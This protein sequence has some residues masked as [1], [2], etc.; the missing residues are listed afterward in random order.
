MLML[1]DDADE[2]TVVE[3][4]VP[5][6]ETTETCEIEPVTA[7]QSTPEDLDS[8]RRVISAKPWDF[9]IPSSGLIWWVQS[10]HSGDCRGD[11]HD[12]PRM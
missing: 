9:R 10:A 8:L 11:S 12:S 4:A 7:A 3:P 6:E 1:S 5:V 2:R